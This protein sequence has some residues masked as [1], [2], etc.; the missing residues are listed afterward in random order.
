MNNEKIL[1]LDFGGHFSQFVARKVREC[2]VYCEVEPSSFSV[3]DIKKFIPKGIIL[4][5]G[6]NSTLHLSDEELVNLG[7]PILGIC[8]GAKI[9]KEYTNTNLYYIDE[10]PSILDEKLGSDKLSDF[11]SSAVQ[12]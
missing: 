2:S 5:G 12:A 7:Y 6:Q 4:V 9:L 10:H 3:E 8:H 1:I 11:P